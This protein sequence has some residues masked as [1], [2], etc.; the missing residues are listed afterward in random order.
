MKQA[1]PDYT[2]FRGYASDS[3]PANETVL[4]KVT[5]SS[6]GRTRNIPSGIATEQQGNYVCATCQETENAGDISS[7]PDSPDTKEDSEGNEE[8]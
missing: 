6:C 3:S 2:G 4:D 8:P 1:N 7:D 5:C